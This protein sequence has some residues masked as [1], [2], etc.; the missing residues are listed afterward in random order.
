M[1]FF[2]NEDEKKTSLGKI[3]NEIARLFS[4]LLKIKESDVCV[5]YVGSEELKCFRTGINII[6]GLNSLS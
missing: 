1:K 5:Y 2:I 3:N 4:I 6:N